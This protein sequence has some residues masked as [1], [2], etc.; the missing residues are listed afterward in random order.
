M[1]GQ[2]SSEKVVDD[3]NVTYFIMENTYHRATDRDPK[4]SCCV[5]A[6]SLARALEV[7]CP[8]AHR[9]D[10]FSLSFPFFSNCPF[11]LV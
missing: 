8:A 4:I 1:E 7:N 2:I 9:V 11:S 6:P 10:P 3:E 5:S